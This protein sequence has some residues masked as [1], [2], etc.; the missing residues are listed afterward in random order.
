MAKNRRR[1]LK[2]QEALNNE[3]RKCAWL[4]FE[5]RKQRSK[6]RL[7]LKSTNTHA[8]VRTRASEIQGAL[9]QNAA[10]WPGETLAKPDGEGRRFQPSSP[11]AQAEQHEQI[12]QKFTKCIWLEP[13]RNEEHE[14]HNY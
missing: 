6:K 10:F 12:F 14:Y 5:H 9:T 13:S 2:V 3:M 4:G 7:K 1:V 8:K 11:M